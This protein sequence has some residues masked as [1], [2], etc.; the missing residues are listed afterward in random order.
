MRNSEPRAFDAYRALHP[1][2]GDASVQIVLLGEKEARRISLDSAPTLPVGRARTLPPARTGTRDSGAALPSTIGLALDEL[3][4]KSDW[5][6][7]LLEGDLLSGQTDEIVQ[8]AMLDSADAALIYWDEDVIERGQRSDPWIKPGWDDLLFSRLGGLAGA[9]VV[10]LAA[11][12]EAAKG[13]PELKFNRDG[14]EC[15][16]RGIARSAPQRVTHLPLVL[17]HRSESTRLPKTLE[18]ALSSEGPSIQALPLPKVSVIVPT[19]DRAD[20]LAACMK[21]ISATNYRGQ[22]EVILVDNGTV[23]SQA[24][25][26]IEEQEALGAKVL[27]DDGPFNFSRLNNAAVEIATGEFLCFLNNDVEP[28]DPE[29]LNLMM[30]YAVDGR[31]GAVGALL[32]YP[33]GRIQHAGVVVGMGGA[34]GHIEKGVRPDERR[35]RTWHAVTREVSAVTAA[36]M[37]VRKSSFESVGGFD[38]TAFPVAFN[39][40]DLCLRLKNSGLRNIFVAEARLLH[41]ESESRGNDRRPERAGKFAAELRALQQRWGTERFEDPHFSPQFVRA[42]EQCVLAP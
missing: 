4:S 6:L 39:D 21:G 29:W 11:A 33:S 9:S 3:A 25:G 19:R 35:H 2:T 10:S 22:L 36:V 24:L 1:A 8:R 42:T 17:T 12:R 31:S 32:L 13:L 14:L 28:L 23:E 34:A 41:R 20:L 37:V 40:V 27:R 26:I 5:I 30:E 18:S 16:L 38:E 7:P 15:L